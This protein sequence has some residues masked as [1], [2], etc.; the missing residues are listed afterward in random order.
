[1]PSAELFSKCCN[2]HFMESQGEGVCWEFES[3]WVGFGVGWC[4]AEQPAMQADGA[5]FNSFLY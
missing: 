3:D 4:M 1:M 2:P 5:K